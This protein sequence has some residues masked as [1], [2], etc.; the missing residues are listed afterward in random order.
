M[1]LVL[2][3]AAALAAG[4]TA[5]GAQATGLP[6]SDACHA[7]KPCVVQCG[8]E[9]WSVPVNETYTYDDLGT[10][11]VRMILSKATLMQSTNYFMRLAVPEGDKV[12]IFLAPDQ[13]C[14]TYGFS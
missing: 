10:A 5:Q 7:A 13:Q 3:C 14:V 11:H 9:L 2:L 12:E 4:L 6:T 8:S 1:K